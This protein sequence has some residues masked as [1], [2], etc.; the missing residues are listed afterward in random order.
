M[1]SIGLEGQEIWRKIYSVG[2]WVELVTITRTKEETTD[3][4]PRTYVTCCVP[5]P[6]RVAPLQQLSPHTFNRPLHPA[7]QKRSVSCWLYAIHSCGVRHALNSTLAAWTTTTTNYHRRVLHV[8]F[9]QRSTISIHLLQ[10]LAVAN[11]A[12]CDLFQLSGP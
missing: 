9:V 1:P 10:R 11:R 8:I 4:S 2:G 7:Q 3:H 5:F 6:R 12:D